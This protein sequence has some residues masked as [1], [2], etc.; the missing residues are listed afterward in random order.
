MK[1]IN[2]D[3]EYLFATLLRPKC[4]HEN[5]RYITQRFYWGLH[6]V[7]FWKC[8]DCGAEIKLS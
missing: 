3:A 1:V 4:T 8:L 6:Q 5:G 7:V 2:E